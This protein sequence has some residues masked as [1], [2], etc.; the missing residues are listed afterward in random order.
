MA[1]DPM[2]TFILEWS[3]WT[4]TI[5]QH[6]EPI[7]KAK[8]FLF[9]LASYNKNN[10]C[11][12]GRIPI[13]LQK[14]LEDTY[15]SRK[16]FDFILENCACAEKYPDLPTIDDSKIDHVAAA[17]LLALWKSIGNP[18]VY[19]VTEEEK[20]K[21]AAENLATKSGIKLKIIDSEEALRILEPLN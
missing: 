5:D 3:I 21:K 2:P 12:L 16:V 7:T 13:K 20:T 15:G 6:Y 17:I 11:M 14:L 19:L 9:K 10:D 18:N 1:P 8:T 4:H